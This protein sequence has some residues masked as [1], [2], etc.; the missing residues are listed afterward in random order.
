MLAVT[1]CRHAYRHVSMHQNVCAHVYRHA[2]RHAYT[3]GPI[4]AIVAIA[5]IAAIAAIGAIRAICAISNMQKLGPSQFVAV[6]CHCQDVIHQDFMERLLVDV[7]M[8]SQPRKTG[9]RKRPMLDIH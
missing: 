6:S 4:W 7:A 2:Y 5:A 9:F 3:H 8:W 1:C